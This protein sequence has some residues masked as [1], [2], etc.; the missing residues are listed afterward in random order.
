[1]RGMNVPLT[2]AVSLP[3]STMGLSPEVLA[4]LGFTAQAEPVRSAPQ[5]TARAQA[6]STATADAWL[7]QGELGRTPA[8]SSE[9]SPA[10]LAEQITADSSAATDAP[11]QRTLAQ[12]R[13]RNGEAWAGAVDPRTVHVTQVPSR[14]NRNP[15]AG[16]KDCGP[17]S[18]VM[19]ARL[20]G[21]HLPGVSDRATAQA[22]INRARALGGSGPAG[23]STTNLELEQA[24]RRS[25]AM[26]SQV[27]SID[28]VHEAVLAG[29]P[30]ILNGNPRN[31]GAYGH[32]FRASD[33]VPFNGAH[34]IVVSGYDTRSGMYL[35]NDPLSKVGV[36]KVSREQL[37]AYLGGSLGLAVS[38]AS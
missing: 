4:T 30:V 24:L 8:T 19:A 6:S 12:A 29:S 27:R 3:V 23:T 26:V 20:L 18:V 16:N 17:A 32:A 5:A 36:L 31:A 28:A 9:P 14:Y 1:M 22:R 38:R 33:L 34:W 21:L 2:S 15:A 7:G 11:T 37:A 25:G 13:G 35:I 10:G